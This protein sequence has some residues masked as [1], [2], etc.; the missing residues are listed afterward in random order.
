MSLNVADLESV[1]TNRRQIVWTETVI[2]WL[3]YRNRHLTGL[4]NILVRLE[5]IFE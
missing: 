5:Y 3:V 2:V 1:T 4:N